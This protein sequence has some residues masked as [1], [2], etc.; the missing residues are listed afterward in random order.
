MTHLGQ[1]TADY[2]S[3]SHERDF[4]VI[5]TEF[6]QTI[7]GMLKDFDSNNNVHDDAL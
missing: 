4:A 7:M 5:L 2:I 1:G 3:V 6:H